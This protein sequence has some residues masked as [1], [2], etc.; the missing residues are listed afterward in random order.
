[1][2]N[3]MIIAFLIL[4]IATVMLQGCEDGLRYVK[5]DIESL[6]DKT[7]YYCGKDQVLDFAGGVV[8]LETFDGRR[9]TV[10]M[11]K[12]TYQFDANGAKES[13][14]SY[15]SSDINF[16]IP[17]EYTVTIWQNKELYC[18]FNVSLLQ[19]GNA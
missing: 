16:E 12:Y 1:M 19:N 8:A 2:K 11:Q 14:E 3:K 4:F 7:V 9:E 17:G 18:T 15:I 5:M 6:P 10:P 13:F